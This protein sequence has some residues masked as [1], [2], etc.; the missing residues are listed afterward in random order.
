M[1]ETVFIT[2]GAGFIGSHLAAKLLEHG[3]RVVIYDSF[4]AFIPPWDNSRYH[5]F[6]TYRL[7]RLKTLAAAHPQGLGSLTIVEGDIRNVS[8]MHRVLAQTKPDVVVHLAAIPIADASK[9][10]IEDMMAINLGGTT[11]VLNAVKDLGIRR[12]VYTSSSMIYGNFCRF[13]ADEDHPA[14]P[15]E[16]YGATKYCGEVMTKTFGS[17][18]GL[19]YVI[20]RPCS[21]YGPTDCNRRIVQRFIEFAMNGQEVSLYDG[22]QSCLDFTYVEDV[23]QGFFLAATHPAAAG[24]IFNLTR[25]EGRTLLDLAEI[26]R[27]HYPQLKIRQAGPDPVTRPK[28]GAMAIGKAARAVGFTPKYSLEDGVAKYVEFYRKLHAPATA[29]AVPQVVVLPS[30]VNKARTQS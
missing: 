15:L 4:T 25:G 17:M 14:N 2:G 24:Q 10:F 27:K 1:P 18:F 3:D 21:V 23:A 12:L 5:Q 19:E 28:R 29:S 8:L 7:D 26:V 22:G 30:Q 11:N 9:K 20:V 6:L 16:T 13:P